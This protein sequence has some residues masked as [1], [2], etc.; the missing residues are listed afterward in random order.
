MKPGNPIKQPDDIVDSEKCPECWDG[1]IEKE[2]GIIQEVCPS[3]G[4]TGIKDYMKNQGDGPTLEESLKRRLPHLAD[5]PVPEPPGTM[6]K[7]DLEALSHDS[8]IPAVETI[9]IPSE[10][11]DKTDDSTSDSGAGR[12]NKVAGSKAAGKP[13]KPRKPKAPKKPRK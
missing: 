5:I 10:L 4:G 8:Y 7:E 13:A 3:C 2:G 12:G 11:E 9:I 6:T 1:F